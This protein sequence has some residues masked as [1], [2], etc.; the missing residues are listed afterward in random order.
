[1]EVPISEPEGGC[2]TYWRGYWGLRAGAR[3]W[4]RE[5]VGKG[6]FRTGV[7]ATQV[8][9]QA[10]GFWNREHLVQSL[11]MKGKGERRTAGK[12]TD[13]VLEIGVEVVGVGKV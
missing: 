13:R 8:V 2:A 7:W 5:P 4:H 12:G 9:D 6:A 1:M 11:E 10:M 3:R